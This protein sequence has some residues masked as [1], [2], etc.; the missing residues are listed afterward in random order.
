MFACFLYVL[1]HRSKASPVKGAQ[2]PDEIGEPP[3]GFAPLNF[4]EE[5]R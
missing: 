3:A 4:T 2:T 5:V 1:I